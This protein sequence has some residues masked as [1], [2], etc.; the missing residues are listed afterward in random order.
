[1]GGSNEKDKIENLMALCRRCHDHYGDKK[2]WME[3][4]FV[5]HFRF[6]QLKRIQFDLTF[7]KNFISDEN[8]HVFLN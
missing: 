1:M 5:V 2:E 3:Y 4:L 6:L 8:F 7:G